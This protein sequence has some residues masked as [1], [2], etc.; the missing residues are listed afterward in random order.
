MNTALLLLSLWSCSTAEQAPP[1]PEAAPPVQALPLEGAGAAR[2]APK[3]PLE[4]AVRPVSPEV[5]AARAQLETGDAV[6]ALAALDAWLAAHPDDSDAHYWRARAR[7][8]Q[9]DLP[10]A[11]S[12]LV[13]ALAGAPEWSNPRQQLAD[14]MV[15]AKRCPEALPLI[16]RLIVDNPNT[17]ALHVNRAFC[18]NQAGRVDEALTDLTKACTAGLQTACRTG[19]RLRKTQELRAEQAAAGAA[20]APPGATTAPAAAAEPDA[21]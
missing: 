21:P 6:G 11:E 10:G 4:E 5:A 16:E 3:P 20:A 8:Q 19:E 7:Q 9:G 15:G 17:P 13:A 12:D 2:A 14:L 18:L 1:P